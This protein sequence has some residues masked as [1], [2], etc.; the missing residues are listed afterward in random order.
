MPI[1]TATAVNPARTP[2]CQFAGIHLA[3][4]HQMSTA[5]ADPHVPGPGRSRPAPKKVATRVAQS[6][7]GGSA[8]RSHISVGSLFIASVANILDFRV[9]GVLHW[10][11][12]DI[13]SASPFAQ[14]NQPAAVTTEREVLAGLR[15]GLL[16]DRTLQL[17]LGLARHSSIVDGKP[18]GRGIWPRTKWIRPR[19]QKVAARDRNFPDRALFGLIRVIRG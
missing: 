18:G 17:D 1:A 10:R 3:N 6:G 7:A 11:G 12:D 8:R 16:A 4:V 14:I 9:V 2:G 13:L 15:H 5:A 19:R